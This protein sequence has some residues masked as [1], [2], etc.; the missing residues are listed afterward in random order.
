ME[1]LFNADDNR[2][3]IER[4]NRLSPDTRPLWGKMN[5]SQ[6]LA[7]SQM[8]LLVA[9]GEHKIKRG[10]MGV[11]FGKMVKN[12]LMKNTSFKRNLPTAKSFVI[13]GQKAFDL[14]KN[15]LTALIQRFIG[16]G[17]AALTKDAHPFFGK[18][19]THEWDVLQWKHLDHHL[20]QFGV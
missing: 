14:E 18:L 7:H 20:K 4:I 16:E 6:M 12:Q 11:L 15:K 17:E 19:T 2:R 5:V 3:M 13:T 1:S 9:F 8:P 10:L